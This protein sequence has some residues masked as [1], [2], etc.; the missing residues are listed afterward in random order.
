MPKQKARQ[1]AVIGAGASGLVTMKTLRENGVD[2]VGYEAGSTVGGLWIYEND[3]GLSSAYRTL[4]INTD[5]KL[6]AFKDWPFPE[7]LQPYPDHYEV[8][9]YFQSYAQRFGLN[10]VIQFSTW[11]DKI[12]P[13]VQADGPQKWEVITRDG[14]KDV[15]DAVVVATG[16]LS[17]PNHV[18]KFRTDFEG[19]YLHAHYYREPDPYVGKR[20][21]VVGIG[22]TA[23][24]IATDISTTT[25]S[26]VLVA[27]SGVLIR[28]KMMFGMPFTD[29]AMLFQRWWIPAKVRAKIVGSLIYIAY[30]KMEQHGFRPLTEKTHP[31]SNGTIIHHIQYRHIRV[32]H[33]IDSINGKKVTFDDGTTEEFDVLI[34]A[35]GYEVTLPM[36]DESL[37]PRHGNKIGL[38]KRVVAHE[39]PGLYFAGLINAPDVSLNY[40]FE[41]QAEYI[42]E[43]LTGRADLPSTQKM[44]EDI[45]AKERW[46]RSQ[47]RDTPRHTI[48][49]EMM[50]YTHE[51]RRTVQEGWERAGTPKQGRRRGLLRRRRVE[52]RG[53]GPLT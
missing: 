1:V 40:A 8:G 45:E 44:A 52:K 27:R 38:Y 34:G 7:D 15:Y 18:E 24:D 13:V 39:Q 25:R 33:D 6:T 41:R 46:L 26:T 2:V 14:E 48:E 31:T 5:K 35:T 53:L 12:E 29:I 23:A 42:A 32:K 10:S 36:V 9:A 50:P 43:L 17:N 37:I 51:L 3:N 30:G 22:N 28:P 47:Y 20:V 19:E 16:H 4:H 49:E 11:V 21:C